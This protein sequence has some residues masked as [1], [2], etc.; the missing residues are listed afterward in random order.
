MMVEVLQST[1]SCERVK[2]ACPNFPL[3][4]CRIWE[5]TSTDSSIERAKNGGAEPGCESVKKQN[6]Q[7]DLR[8]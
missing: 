2:K 3:A 4:P 7:G 6:R 1:G 8:A 5:K